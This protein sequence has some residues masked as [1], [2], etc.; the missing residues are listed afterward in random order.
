MFC[1][2]VKSDDFSAV[3]RSFRFY[4]V[5]LCCVLIVMAMQALI[6]WRLWT[7]TLRALLRSNSS[8]KRR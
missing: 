7:S 5:S 6:Q 4:N 1:E 8:A 3:V 2:Y